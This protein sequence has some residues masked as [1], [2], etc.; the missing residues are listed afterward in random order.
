MSAT[1]RTLA[2]IVVVATVGGG[3][4]AVTAFADDPT[5]DPPQVPH[6][7]EEIVAEYA[8]QTPAPDELSN[9]GRLKFSFLVDWVNVDEKGA[10][11]PGPV[12]GSYVGGGGT[13]TCEADALV[14]VRDERIATV[15]RSGTATDVSVG[16]MVKDGKGD[17]LW[18]VYRDDNGDLQWGYAP[19]SCTD[20]G[21]D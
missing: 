21:V 3:I 1:L 7:Y 5:D 9:S 6:T 15:V 17:G 18:K 11:I 13:R 14:D 10:P 20:L 12:E 19:G 16:E 8:K 4:L 2:A